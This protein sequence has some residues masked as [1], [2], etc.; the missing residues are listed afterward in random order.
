MWGSLLT[1]RTSRGRETN[2]RHVERRPD[3]L[4]FVTFAHHTFAIAARSAC[5]LGRAERSSSETI[6][7]CPPPFAWHEKAR[8]VKENGTDAA[9]DQQS[10][11]PKSIIPDFV[12]DNDFQWTRCRAFRLCACTF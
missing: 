6:S 7:L 9:G 11:K 12:A 8:G 4:V 5:L 10:R 1:R 2:T 3:N